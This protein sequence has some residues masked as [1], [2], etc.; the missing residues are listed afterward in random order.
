MLDGLF[1][2]LDEMTQRRGLEKIRTIGDA[3]MVAA[4]VPTPRVD[5]APVLVALGLEMLRA[6]QAT[7]AVV[8]PSTAGGHRAGSPWSPV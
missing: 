5:H 4:G 7:A 6:A 8:T 2:R 1:A 3:Y